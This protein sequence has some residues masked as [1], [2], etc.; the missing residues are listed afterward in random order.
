M[1]IDVVIGWMVLQVTSH[2]WEGILIVTYSPVNNLW[3][4]IHQVQAKYL[5]SVSSR[6]QRL[7]SY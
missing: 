1:P 5:Q 3:W 2:S 6:L 7:G 4:K